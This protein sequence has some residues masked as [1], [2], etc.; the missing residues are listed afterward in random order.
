M[1]YRLASILAS[2]TATTAATKTVDIN[3]I[4]P[5][6]QIIVKYNWTN[7]D[8]V[9]DGH[10]A[11]M[12]SKIEVVD[13]S[14]VLA[15]LSGIQAEALHFFNTK[16][17][18]AQ[19]LEY[20]NG[21]SGTVLLPIDFG[22]F[23]HDTQLAFLPKKFRNPQIKVTHNIALGGSSVSSS[24]LEIF[25]HI[26]DEKAI[27]PIGFLLSK[28]FFSYTL[29]ANQYK[30][31]DLPTDHILR[32]LLIKALTDNYEITD[33]FAE[34]KVSEDN[35]KK[36]P[37]N[38]DMADLIQFARQKYG[39]YHEQIVGTYPDIGA[40]SWWVTPSNKFNI[41][42]FNTYMQVSGWGDESYGGHYRGECSAVCAWRGNCVGF[43]PH[44][45]VPLDFGIQDDLNDWYDVTKL[46]SLILR[47][48][49]G[50]SPSGTGE[51]ITQQLRKY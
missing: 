34:V 21:C 18:R 20:R 23:L 22:R 35:D 31:I 10:P 6:S 16:E 14:E 36:V 1:K 2:E 5:I 17:C 47:L 38:L 4:D 51:I 45:C 40:Q 43:E 28:E 24:S 3:L 8:H 41:G 37:Y 29:V 49:D 44:G 32:K 30:S 42:L 12:V 39:E 33:Q 15:S 50:S 27:S 9:A 19:E 25:A 26:F 46:G 13:G 48:K 11:K 7:G